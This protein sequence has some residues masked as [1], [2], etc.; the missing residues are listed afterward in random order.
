MNAAGRFASM[1]FCLGA[2][3]ATSALA[4]ELPADAKAYIDR[5]TGCN[6]WLSEP[7]TTS[8]RK[9]EIARHIR[10][11]RCTTLDHDESEMNARYRGKPE[12]LTAIA[13][14]HDAM[15]D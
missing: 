11:L 7:A 9:L 4:D 12:M 10:E 6:Y 3:F 13:D 8:L 1:T 15:P 14:A 2:L 5:R